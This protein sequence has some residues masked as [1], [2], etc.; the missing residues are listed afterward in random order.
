MHINKTVDMLDG[1][2]W[3]GIL[4]FAIP[5]AVSSVLQQCFNAA[6]MAIVGRFEG[7]QALA[8]VGSNGAF[9]NLLINTFVGL[10]V[11]ANVVIGPHSGS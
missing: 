1:P 6:D 10:S 3:K 9:I 2:L 8:A 7:E 4:Y 5:I 11:G